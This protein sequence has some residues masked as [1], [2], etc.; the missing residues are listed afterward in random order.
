MVEICDAKP[1][2][3]ENAKKPESVKARRS[4]L[5]Q[6]FYP[7]SSLIRRARLIRRSTTNHY[8]DQL[9]QRL[10]SQDGALIKQ[11]LIIRLRPKS[12][13]SEFE[14]RLANGVSSDHF[15]PAIDFAYPPLDEKA[16]QYQPAIFYP[17]FM[18]STLQ[19]KESL[20]SYPVILTDD[21][22][23]RTFA[24]CYKF[25]PKQ[26]RSQS[27]YDI[28]N[29]NLQNRYAVL[30]FISDFRNEP[31]FHQLAENF[32]QD[33]QKD[34]TR[35]FSLCK[36]LLELR[37]NGTKRSIATLM[38][39]LEWPYTLIP[40]VPD[41]RTEL[42]YNPTPYI[43]GILRYNLNKVR[44]L[45][46]PLPGESEDEIVIIDVE[47]GIILPCL[48]LQTL[49]D[50]DL[51]SKALLNWAH[52]MGFPKALVS[53]LLTSLRSALP[54]NKSPSR[55]DNKIE[56]RVMIWYAKI[57]GHYKAYGDSL[58]SSRSRKKLSSSHPSPDVREM[59][60]WFVE[61]GVL[62]TFFFN[63]INNQSSGTAE[64]TERFQKIIKQ[65]KPPVDKDGNLRK[66]KSLLWRLFNH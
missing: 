66:A 16:H 6:N 53:E 60:Q 5:F 10:Q 21:K 9:K 34:V 4:S 49:R 62:Q 55:A 35:A 54:I 13:V 64:Q 37:I 11:I 28:A 33:S 20:D 38:F 25:L 61:A 59:L 48:P 7:H 45:I 39:P 50:N 8:C 51:R 32:V 1:L 44:D 24:Y 58:L 14:N 56:K 36:E 57:F 22:G 18:R 26:S 15:I 41:S 17:D 42:C 23:D 65:Y 31:L 12:D 19:C 52:N 43:C 40:V 29:G 2:V 3:V 47:R 63:Q 27:D 46:V 30:V